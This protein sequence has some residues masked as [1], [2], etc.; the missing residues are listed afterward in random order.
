MYPEDKQK[1]LIKLSVDTTLALGFQNGCF[2]VEAKYTSRGPRI[3]E[4]NA[5]MGGV[6]VRD[7][8]LYAWGVVS[9]SLLLF[10]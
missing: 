2:H 6:S 8:N 4:V 10:T 5:R 9:V 3:I 1:E 7:V